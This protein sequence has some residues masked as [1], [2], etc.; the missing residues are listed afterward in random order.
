MKLS[1]YKQRRLDLGGF[2]LFSAQ[3]RCPH[4]SG[5]T[6]GLWNRSQQELWEFQPVTTST[7]ADLS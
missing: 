3:P 5:R 2:G 4:C 1:L 6:S 7:Q